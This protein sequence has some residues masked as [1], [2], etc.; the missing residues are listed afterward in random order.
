[1]GYRNR[2]RGYQELVVWRDAL[3]LLAMTHRQAGS[4]PYHLRRTLS[5]QIA[6]ADSVHRN[7]A[8]GW[9]RRSLG[10]YLYFL[11]VALGSLGEFVSGLEAYRHAAILSD[12]C[13]AE[14]D[15]HAF[16]TEN[17]LLC[18]VDSIRAKASA[19]QGS[20]P[21]AVREDPATY[22]EFSVPILPIPQSPTSPTPYD[23]DSSL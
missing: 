21:S 2:N 16:K 23:K 19:E 14:M 20:K 6:C 15:A 8:E 12:D 7:I 22:G 3:E 5:Q 4:F 10:E 18:L 13:I 11:N 17:E 9:C 1:M